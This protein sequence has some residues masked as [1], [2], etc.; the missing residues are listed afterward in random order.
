VNRSHKVI[1]PK[2][3][4]KTTAFCDPSF[5]LHSR[6]SSDLSQHRSFGAGCGA[7]DGFPGGIWIPSFLLLL[8][9]TCRKASA[10]GIFS[11]LASRQTSPLC[12]SVEA[13]LGWSLA[14]KLLCG[15]LH[16]HT[17]RLRPFLLRLNAPSS[18][19]AFSPPRGP[20]ISLSVVGSNRLYCRQATL[21]PSF[22]SIDSTCGA[23][24]QV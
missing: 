11:R 7:A 13:C 8:S 21:N 5:T 22:E 3:S 2:E 1:T 23:L 10:G 4:N 12:N 15:V 18:V 24:R 14:C 19:G 16:R 9:E 17:I 6:P 20:L